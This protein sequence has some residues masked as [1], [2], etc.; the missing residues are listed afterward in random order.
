MINRSDVFLILTDQPTKMKKYLYLLRH[1]YAQSP[2][3]IKD[4]E[5][6]LTMEGHATA[7]SLG[8]K[9]ASEGFEVDEM[10]CSPAQRT[11]ETAIDVME[12]LKLNEQIL[13]VVDVVYD[14]SVREMLSTINSLDPSMEKVLII[15]HNPAISFIGEYIT[16]EPIGAVEPC[17]LVSI[18]TSLEWAAISKG[19]CAF[20]SYYHP[21]AREL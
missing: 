1:S 21:K 15:G 20:E 4:I 11:R 3:G 10:V 5:R 6:V 2:G 8:R 19:V 17:G 13:K 16:G 7:R 12:E 18:T 14:A 9:L